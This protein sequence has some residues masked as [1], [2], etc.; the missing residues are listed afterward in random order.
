[1]FSVALSVET[2]LGVVPRVY[3]RRL[4][5]LRGI[6]PCGV[7][8]FLPA[9]RRSDS[10]PFQNRG[11]YRPGKI[12]WQGNATGGGMQ[13]SSGDRQDVVAQSCTRQPVQKTWLNQVVEWDAE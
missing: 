8:T 2:P 9:K 1:M 4:S 7:R 5:G 6:A 12:N 10:P 13:N 3:P 11:D